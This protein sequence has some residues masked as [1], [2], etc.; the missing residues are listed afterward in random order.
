[1]KP[2]AALE[3]QG[4]F[5]SHRRAKTSQHETPLLPLPVGSPGDP[6]PPQ[7]SL[8]VPSLEL[9]RLMDTSEY[10]ADEI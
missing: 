2:E 3:G 7:K 5:T 10:K 9:F 6:E 1:M 8:L 4:G